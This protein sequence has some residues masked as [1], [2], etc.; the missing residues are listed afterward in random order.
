[1]IVFDLRRVLEKLG[2]GGSVIGAKGKKGQY[3]VYRKK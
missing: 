2:I 1:V 3:G